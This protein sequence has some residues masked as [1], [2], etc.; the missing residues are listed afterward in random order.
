MNENINVNELQA[1]ISA[2][3]KNVRNGTVY[4]VM[5]YSEP[6]AVILSYEEY[7]KL[8]GECKRCIQDLRKIA[9]LS[10]VKK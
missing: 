10:E 8:K 1:Q 2:V 3:L 7:L 6:I 5:R 4:E 9:K